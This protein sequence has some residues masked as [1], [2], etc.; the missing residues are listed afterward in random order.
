MSKLTKVIAVA[1]LC[2]LAAALSKLW[3]NNQ[4]PK[5]IIVEINYGDAQPART[6]E[7]PL[8]EDRSILEILQAVAVVETHPVGGY[9]FV[10]SIDGVKG[11]RGEMAWYYA[12]DG[13]SADKLA[14]SNIP[15][16]N[17]RYIQWTYK[18]DTCSEKADG[19]K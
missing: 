18:K 10:T 13:K 14:Y 1:A 9:V 5:N 15:D 6:V 4:S 7:T 19:K 2:I 12:V 11:R 17:V 16:S 3:A 8:A